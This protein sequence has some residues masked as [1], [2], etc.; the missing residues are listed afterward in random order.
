MILDLSSSRNKLAGAYKN[1]S[2]K[3]WKLLSR[4][5]YF[6]LIFL[7]VPVTGRAEIRDSPFPL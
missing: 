5:Q 7:N 3:N 6:H 1:K 2:E 4:S